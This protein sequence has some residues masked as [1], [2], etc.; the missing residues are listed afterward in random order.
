MVMRATALSVSQFACI[1]NKTTTGCSVKPSS[2]ALGNRELIA[3]V[4]PNVVRRKEAFSPR[5]VQ[6]RS[7]NFVLLWSCP[8]RI[9]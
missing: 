5:N 7:V 2:N 6:D 4:L 1:A 3:Q 8:T 9:S